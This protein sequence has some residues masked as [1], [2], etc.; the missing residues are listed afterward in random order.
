MTKTPSIQQKV[1]EILEVLPLEKQQ[2]ILSFVKFIQSQSQMCHPRKSIK[3][4]LSDFP[5]DLTE[6][7][8]AEARKEI[9]ANFPREIEE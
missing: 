8:F 3:G 6:E 4:I 1:L 5:I 7:E 9:W 2:E